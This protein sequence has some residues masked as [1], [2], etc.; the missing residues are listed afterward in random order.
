VLVQLDA[1]NAGDAAALLVD[2]EGCVSIAGACGCSQSGL[3]ELS[4]C[5][6]GIVGK[7]PSIRAGSWH[8]VV[9][10]VTA[11]QLEVL[12]DGKFVLSAD[13]AV[14]VAPAALA[15][16]VSAGGKKQVWICMSCITYNDLEATACKGCNEDRPN[17]P[18]ASCCLA[19]CASQAFRCACCSVCGR[20][21]GQICGRKEG[22]AACRCRRCRSR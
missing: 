5:C 15:P 3:A 9:V 19:C 6:E 16:A 7:F 11:T 8:R 21:C 10:A 13:N 17:D 20:G 4:F 22:S 18:G 1:N 2:G 14:P 12:V